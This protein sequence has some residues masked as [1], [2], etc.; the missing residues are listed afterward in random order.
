MNQAL[1]LY[2]VSDVPKRSFVTS[3][4]LSNQNAQLEPMRASSAAGDLVG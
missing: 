3:H 2:F 1:S 4:T